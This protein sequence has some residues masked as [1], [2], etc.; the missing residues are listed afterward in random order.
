MLT[1]KSVLCRCCGEVSPLVLRGWLCYGFSGCTKLKTAEVRPAMWMI[2][3]II[4]IVPVTSH[5]GH[6]D[7]PGRTLRP[8]SVP[9][10]KKNDRSSYKWHV[11]L[12]YGLIW[13]IGIHILYTYIIYI[14]Y[15]HI[16]YIYI[17]Y[18]Y[19]YIT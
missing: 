12:I 19:T 8:H 1:E 10:S 5:G 2:P 18:T 3:R 17:Y 9:L 6:S 7:V 14:Y 13:I 16:L 4:T 11:P 15:I